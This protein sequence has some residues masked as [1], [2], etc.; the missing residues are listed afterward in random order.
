MNGFVRLAAL[1]LA[2]SAGLPSVA[3]AQL[4]EVRD[5]SRT[6]GWTVTPIFGLSSAWDDNVSMVGAGEPASSDVITL[7]SPSI[8]ADY[9]GKR[10]WLGAGYRGSFSVYRQLNDLNS[11]EQHLRV[12]SR[13]QM[14]KRLTLSLH[15]SFAAVPTTDAVLLSGVPFLRTGSRVNDT[16]ASLRAEVGPHTTASMGYSFT[17]V[18][19]DPES[20]FADLLK[21]GHGHSVDG[22]VVRRLS[23]R[24]S[25]GA[26]ASF[27]RLIIDPSE[28]VSIFD[29]GATMSFEGTKTLTLSAALG[30]SRVTDAVRDTTKTGPAWRVAALQRF[31]R[32]TLTA[33]WARS[34]APAFGLGGSVQNEEL[35]ASLMM[36]VA[37]NRL[38][39]QAG[40]SYRRNEPLLPDGL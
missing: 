14:T 23:S 18:A 9:L 21:G 31:E 3:G 40:L 1:A 8:E 7:F 27:R 13:H 16:G 24:L 12:D 37:R 26:E 10:N 33:S 32:A 19:F 29:T 17:W 25:V 35:N 5:A 36:P 6:P 30:I 15:E 28:P 34:F 38:Y 39:W 22:N 20:P 2:V 11:F 4:Q